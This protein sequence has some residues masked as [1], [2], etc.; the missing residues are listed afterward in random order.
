[1]VQGWR[2]ATQS[3]LVALPTTSHPQL[4]KGKR[5]AV[6]KKRQYS[7]DTSANSGRPKTTAIIPSG[8]TDKAST[9]AVVPTKLAGVTPLFIKTPLSFITKA[10]ST[11]ARKN[12]TLEVHELI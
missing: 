5:K 6:D 12:D 8:S 3:V 11:F 2:G 1:M 9:T 7:A 4:R 10:P